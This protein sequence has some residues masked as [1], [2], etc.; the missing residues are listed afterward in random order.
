MLLIFPTPLLIRHLW[1]IKAAVLL[2]WCLICTVLLFTNF[3]TIK[4][5][6][7]AILFCDLHGWVFKALI[8]FLISKNNFSVYLCMSMEET[9]QTKLKS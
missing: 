3:G 6:I 8:I 5:I 9:N 7:V 1:Q 4:V 2:Q